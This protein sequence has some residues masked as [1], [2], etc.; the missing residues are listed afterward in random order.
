[1][2]VLTDP[3]G[4]DH[5]DWLNQ[6]LKGHQLVE[7]EDLAGCHVKPMFGHH[8]CSRKKR[9]TIPYASN[10]GFICEHETHSVWEDVLS[11]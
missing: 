9:V 7:A 11:C 2:A 3:S 1:M 10:K 6:T 8:S 5:G 4:H